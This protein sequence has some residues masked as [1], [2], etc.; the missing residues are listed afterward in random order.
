MAKEAAAMVL[1]DDNFATIVGAVR[2]GRTLYENIISFVRFQLSTT[3]GAVMTLLVAPLAGLPEPFNAIQVLWVAMIMDGPPAVALALDR[4]RPG[5]MHE[6]PRRRGDD[7]LSRRRFGKIMALGATMMA[8]TVGVLYYGMQNGSEARALTLAFT[9]FVLFQFFNVFNARAEKGSTFNSRFFDN[10]MLWAS[11]TA[12]LGLQA[13]AVHW[14]PAQSIFHT[15]DLTASDWLIAVG[16]ASLVLLL[17]EMRKLLARL[18]I[19]RG[20]TQA[21]RASV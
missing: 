21:A 4:P 20:S 9:T 13:V 7:I 1:T 3:T 2:Q 15:A 19:F 6:S 10:P 17:E 18:R 8:G 12:V 5:A 11:L 14:G 16:V